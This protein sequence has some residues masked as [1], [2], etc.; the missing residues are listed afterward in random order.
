MDLDKEVM[1]RVY[2]QE[3]EPNT[4]YSGTVEF[5]KEMESPP[6]SF[7]FR[8][9]HVGHLETVAAL[10]AQGRESVANLRK[11]ANANVKLEVEGSGDSEK[12]KEL[13]RLLFEPVSL[14]YAHVVEQRKKGRGN[15]GTYDI[16]F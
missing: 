12:D 3:T 10:V 8:V 7:R 16:P 6:V 14:A 5:P 4:G 15:E 1:L 2:I 9:K 13:A 11:L